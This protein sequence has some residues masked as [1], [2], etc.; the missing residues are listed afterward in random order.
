MVEFFEDFSKR[1]F[2]VKD[3]QALHALMHPV[4]PFDGPGSSLVAFGSL[5]V[6][7]VSV[8]MAAFSLAGLMVAL[9]VMYVIAAKVFGVQIDL[10]DDFPY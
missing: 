6:L 7:I 10:R 4:A 9:M 1:I 2:G 3:G 8:A 5:M